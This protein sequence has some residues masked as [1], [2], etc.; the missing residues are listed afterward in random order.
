M[1]L[2]T[3]GL[4]N[5]A[6]CIYTQWE[7]DHGWELINI[8]W[9]MQR[10][11]EYTYCNNQGIIS[12]TIFISEKI[13]KAVNDSWSSNTNEWVYWIKEP[14]NLIRKQL[15]SII[16]PLHSFNIILEVKWI[17]SFFWLKD[18]RDLSKM[19]EIK[20]NSY[21]KLS[22]WLTNA[23]IKTST[24]TYNNIKGTAHISK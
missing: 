16:S 8:D 24:D 1:R 14:T 20:I 12:G 17:L 18:F 9:E 2:R 19:F 5:L 22:R 4:S 23:H 11:I 15:S 21:P 3:T 13:R 6:I 7:L 10:N